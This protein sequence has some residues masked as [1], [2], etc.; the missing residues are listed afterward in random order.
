MG[1]T[2][3]DLL[4][5]DESDYFARHL[6][7]V[8]WRGLSFER[9]GAAL[10]GALFD[11]ASL[12]QRRDIDGGELLQRAAVYEQALH[13]CR[14]A[15]EEAVIAASAGTSVVSESIEG[16]GSRTYTRSASKTLYDTEISPRA[17][18]L[19][20]VWLKP[21]RVRVGRG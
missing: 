13:L 7:G 19:V 9:R 14:K 18:R 11:I 12:L 16:L 6:D 10:S 3:L 2:L 21:V 17:L 20:R 1:G 15:D 8:Y 4:L 5:E